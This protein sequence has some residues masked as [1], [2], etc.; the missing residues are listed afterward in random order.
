MLGLRTAFSTAGAEA[1]V[2]TLWR[3]DDEAGRLFMQF[4]YSRL[5]EGPARALQLAQIDMIR[6]TKFNSPYYWSGYVL[7]GTSN[8]D[9]PLVLSSPGPTDK[10]FVRPNCFEFTSHTP[11][12]TIHPVRLATNFGPLVGS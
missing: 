1:L 10:K 4:F 7:S 12:Q 5:S 11:K 2:M 3:T 6:K 8:T 9:K